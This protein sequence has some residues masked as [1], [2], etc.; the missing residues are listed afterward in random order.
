MDPILALLAVGIT[1]SIAYLVSSERRRVQL[2]AWRWAARRSALTEVFETA[3]GL[4]ESASLSGRSGALEVRLEGYR[5]GKHKRGTRIV[6]SGLGHGAGGLSLRRE[7]LATAIEKRVV[8]ER[9]IDTGDPVFDAEYFVQGQASL[10]LAILRP[11]TRRRLAALLRGH[12]GDMPVDVHASL[13]SGVL[14]VQVP[15]NVFSSNRER[16]PEILES[17]LEVARLLVAPSDLARRIAT[18][19]RREPEAGARINRLLILASEFKDHPK[20]RKALRAAARKDPSEEVRLRAAMA[21][22]EEGRETLLDLVGHATSDSCAARA[23]EALG[24]RLPDEVAEATLR[25]ALGR[26][27][28]RTAQAVLAV[29]GRRGAPGTEPLLREALGCEDETIA[30]AAARAL[31]RAGTVAS[32]VALL[33]AG[34]RGGARRGAV[35]QAIAEIQSRLAG[36]EPGQLSLATGA[37]GALSLADGEPGT[38]DLVEAP[39]VPLLD[40]AQG[41][42]GAK[43]PPERPRENN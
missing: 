26:K 43:P 41:K 6:V 13:Q 12:V 33:E 18:N 36:A 37:A 14:E 5:S 28:S 39:V 3:G 4:F 20:A 40:D 31:G 25:R 1:G 10:A 27:S 38:L 8:G 32:V 34:E 11:E 30:V 29:L 7:G 16:I 24:H 2:Q 22:G 42:S 23:V 15:E 17:V 9:D 21:L 35:R 19:L